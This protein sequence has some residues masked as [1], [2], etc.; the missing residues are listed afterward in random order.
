MSTEATA[1]TDFLVRPF[2]ETDEP[3][4]LELLRTSLGGGP[5]GERPPEYFRWKHLENP[6]GR[7]FMTVAEADGRIIGFRALMRWR[8]GVADRAVEAVRPVDTATHPDY[9]GRGVFSTLTLG[10]LDAV[11]GEIDLVFNTPNPDSLRGYL[12]MG[13]QV[14]SEVPISIRIRRPARFIAWKLRRS[15]ATL[16]DRPVVEAPTAAEVLLDER[17]LAELLERA[18][19]PAWGLSTIRTVEHLRWRY[20]QAPLLGYHALR[21]ERGGT[22][23]GLVFF[24]LRPEGALWGFSIADVIVPSGDVETARRL[25][26]AARHAGDVAYVATSFPLGTAAARASRSLMSVPSPRRPT[27]VANPLRSDLQPNPLLRSS[28]AL[29]AGDVEVF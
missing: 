12:K 28:W 26:A 11:R 19:V 17:G 20:A 16:P 29:S 10:A 22:L 5:A 13:W 1:Q 7:S 21:E 14:V 23:A 6:F 24:R 15:D 2:R 25:L 8:F 4:V 3:E 9:R 27:L 18:E